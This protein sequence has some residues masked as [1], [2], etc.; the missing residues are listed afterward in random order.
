[1]D[2]PRPIWTPWE[3]ILEPLGAI[4]EAILDPLGVILDAQGPISTATNTAQLLT[5]KLIWPG[6]MREAIE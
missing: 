4:L 6:G 3:T 5:V 2:A 1:M